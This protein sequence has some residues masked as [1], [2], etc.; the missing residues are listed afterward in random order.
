MATYLELH[1]L[2]NAGGQPAKDLLQKIEVALTVKA[3]AFLSG[4]PT[5]NQAAW[6]RDCLV[7]PQSYALPAMRALVA[8]NNTLTTAQILSVTQ[9]TLQTAV[10][11]L[12]DKIYAA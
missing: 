12:I 8:Q 1:A 10:N 5:A 4:T 7:N 9:E 3:A 2:V 11:T 6:A